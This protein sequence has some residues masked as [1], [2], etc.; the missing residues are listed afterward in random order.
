MTD[1]C[2]AAIEFLKAGVAVG[3]NGHSNLYE[4]VDLGVG[5]YWLKKKIKSFK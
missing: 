2:S 3:Q 1:C 4:I 5:G